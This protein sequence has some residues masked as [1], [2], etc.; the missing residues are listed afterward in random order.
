[1]IQY[2][3]PVPDFSRW[4]RERAQ[5]EIPHTDKL[6]TELSGVSALTLLIEPCPPYL[7]TREGVELSSFYIASNRLHN[8]ARGADAPVPIKPLIAGY[9]IGTYGR[10]GVA[11]IPGIGTRFA[12]RVVAETGEPDGVWEWREDRGFSPECEDCAL[13]LAACPTGALGGSGLVDMEKMFA[14]AGGKRAGVSGSIPSA[15]RRVRLGLRSL[16]GCLPAQSGRAACSDAGAATN[17]R[18]TCENCSRAT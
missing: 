12:A 9:G 7:P 15:H 10:C 5:R 1:M 8:C 4:K 14:R 17:A 3:L 16:P 11:A 18:S 2:R 6:R 13:C